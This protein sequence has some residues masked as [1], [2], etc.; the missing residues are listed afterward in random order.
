MTRQE[1]LTDPDYAPE[2]ET[3]VSTSGTGSHA[4]DPEVTLRGPL[5]DISSLVLLFVTISPIP[6][7]ELRESTNV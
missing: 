6:Q 7:N 3:S 5:S 4:H 1:L 2:S